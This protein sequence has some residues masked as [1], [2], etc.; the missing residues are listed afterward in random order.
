MTDRLADIGARIHG[1]RQ[2]GT[3]VNAMRGIAA[4]RT[5]RARVQL[6]AVDSY[7]ATV[8]AAIGR[9]LELLPPAPRETRRGSTRPAVVLFCAE[10]GFCRRLQRARARRR[11]RRSRIV[12]AV[13]DRHARRRDTCRARR[14]GR[15]ESRYAVAFGGDTE[16]GRPGRRGALRANRDRHDQPTR[17]RLYAVATRPRRRCGTTPAVSVR[18]NG[19]SPCRRPQSAVAQHAAR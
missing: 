3:V 13:S 1:I 16:A 17:G 8:A 4:A 10:Q 7:A 5:Q 12:E 9:A 2:L 14:Q 19:F 18:T 6:A 11:A 15:L